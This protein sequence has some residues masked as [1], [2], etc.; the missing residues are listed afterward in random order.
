MGSLPHTNSNSEGTV[1]LLTFYY[2]YRQRLQLSRRN[3]IQLFEYWNKSEVISLSRMVAS[4]A[5]VSMVILKMTK[6]GIVCGPYVRQSRLDITVTSEQNDKVR[7]RVWPL[8]TSITAWH[9]G[10]IR[11]KRQSPA[12]CVAPTYVNH[13]LTLR[14]YQSK[15]TTRG[16]WTHGSDTFGYHCEICQMF[17][18]WCFMYPHWGFWI[19]C[20]T[21]LDKAPQWL[22]WDMC[23]HSYI[24]GGSLSLAGAAASIIFVATNTCM[25]RQNTSFV[26]TELYLS[27]Q[28]IFV[29]TKHLSRQIFVATNICRDNH[30]FFAT[31]ILLSRQKTYFVSTNTCLLRQKWYLWQLPPVIQL[32]IARSWKCLA[33]WWDHDNVVS[34]FLTWSSFCT[35]PATSVVIWCTWTLCVCRS[36]H[37]EC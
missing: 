17:F 14:L 8:R 4:D 30:V 16:H 1:F 33:W 24:I 7:H 3:F 22:T 15:T 13:G 19:N 2:F 23:C 6:S 35:T 20:L 31:S 21:W 5:S 27:R 25:S 12:S 26:A 28:N 29:A 10:Y 34:M 9:D 18:H 32:V 37:T 36:K 11:A